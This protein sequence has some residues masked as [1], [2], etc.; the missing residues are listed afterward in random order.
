MAEWTARFW[1]PTIV[2]TSPMK[3][4]I[5]TGAAMANCAR[6]WSGTYEYTGLTRSNCHSP[7]IID[8]G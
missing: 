4:C 7:E 5:D 6:E 8:G 1:R 3:R 2:C